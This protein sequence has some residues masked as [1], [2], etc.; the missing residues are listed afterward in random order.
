MSWNLVCRQGF[1][2][3]KSVEIGGKGG[4]CLG[5]GGRVLCVQI[6]KFKF[7]AFESDFA[8]FLWQSFGSDLSL[9]SERDHFL[10]KL[11]VNLVHVKSL[12]HLSL[13]LLTE[14]A[15]H[16]VLEQI[17]RGTILRAQITCLASFSPHL[18]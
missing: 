7:L 18:N 8:D 1:N 13:I 15:A 4:V 11:F 6:W 5:E 16:L 9:V 2:S 14:S 12:S 17:D 3:F 10:V